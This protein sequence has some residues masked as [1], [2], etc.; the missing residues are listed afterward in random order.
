M[1]DISCAP[2]SLCLRL[3]ASLGGRRKG[4]ACVSVV[5]SAAVLCVAS[6]LVGVGVLSGFW[7]GVC[8]SDGGGLHVGAGFVSVLIGVGIWW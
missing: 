1:C 5:G 6:V 3:C 2:G 4:W 7:L 8:C